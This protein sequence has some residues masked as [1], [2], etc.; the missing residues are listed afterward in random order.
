MSTI[1]LSSGLNEQ[2]D[3]FLK[4]LKRFV[5]AYEHRRMLVVTG[6]QIYFP[7]LTFTIG[8]NLMPT[9]TLPRDHAD[10]PFVLG[11]LAFNDSE[12]TVPAPAGVTES[13]ESDNT[14]VVSIDA[15][16]STV[17]FGT[18]GGANLSRKV[19]VDG[20]E[21]IVA[22]ATFNITPGALTVT[23]DVSFPGLTPDA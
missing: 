10:E 15:A 4:L 22:T 3:Q 9:Y 16:T 8:E 17:H 5:V 2:V 21:F 20:N 11:P 13:F 7:G 12:G 18:F 6:G 23:G 19:T 14:D 1:T